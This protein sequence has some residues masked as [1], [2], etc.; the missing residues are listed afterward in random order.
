MC[1]TD[2]FPAQ[3]RTLKMLGNVV[4]IYLQDLLEGNAP[5]KFSFPENNFTSPENGRIVF[6]QT[7]LGG[8]SNDKPSQF[9]RLGRA[10]DCVLRDASLHLGVCNS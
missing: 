1:K 5:S 7:F 2:H 4:E 6:G 9:V 10:V 8:F 3:E